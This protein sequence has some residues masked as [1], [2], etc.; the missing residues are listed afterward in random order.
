MSSPATTIPPGSLVLVTG[1]S[2]FLASHVI[3]QFL[4][5]GY[6]VRGTVRDVQASSWLVQGRFKDY[7]DS[8]ALDLVAVPDLG[9][10]DAYDE[11]IKGVS[12][13]LHIAYVTKIS[14]DPNEVITPSVVGVRSILEAALQESSRSGSSIKEI[15]FTSSAVATSPL[16]QHVDNGAVDRTSWNDAALEAAWARGPPYEMSQVMVNYP[17]SKVAAEK[18]VWKFV[19][20]RNDKIP[21]NVNVVSPAGIIGEP[22][23]RKHIKGQ[24]NWIVHAYKGNKVVMDAMQASFYADVKDVAL[25]HVAAVLDPEVKNARLQTWGRSTHWNDVLGILRKLSPGKLFIDDYPDP[26]HLKVSVDQSESLA[27]LKKWADKND[28]TSLEDSISENINN[29]YLNN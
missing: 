14:P 9:V 12:A 23:N 21:F 11:A 15:V 24:A 13:V 10:A 18:E 7:T 8:G 20:D 26:Y 6:R 4:V 5:L 19:Q 3:W 2:G 29:P 28:W 17:A 22:L 1:A 16:S 25:V 27:L